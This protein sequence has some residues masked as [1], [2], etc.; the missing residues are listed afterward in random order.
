VDDLGTTLQTLGFHVYE[1]VVHRI[2]TSPGPGLATAP[3][4][5]IAP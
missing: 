3:A 1:Q 2:S 5:L 4:I